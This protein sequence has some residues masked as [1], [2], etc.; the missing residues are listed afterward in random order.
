MSSKPL[1]L[2]DYL[3]HILEAIG[4]IERYTRNLS[5]DEFYSNELVQDAVIRNIEVI[6]E[7]SRNARACTDGIF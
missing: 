1:R 5:R 4:R 6:G 3:L 7:A 2:P